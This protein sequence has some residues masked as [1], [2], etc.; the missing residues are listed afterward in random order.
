MNIKQL[1]LKVNFKVDNT[2]DKCLVNSLM[3]SELKIHSVWTDI[4]HNWGIYIDWKNKTIGI[5]H[6][7][8]LNF[9]GHVSFLWDHWY[10][11]FGLLVTFP[12]GS[13]L[14][15]LSRGIHVTLHIPWDSP[16]VQ[17][18]LT[19]WWPSLPHTCKALVGLETRSYHA[20]GHSVRSGRPDFI[21]WGP[22][23]YRKKKRRFSD[24][25]THI[26]L[27]NFFKT[28]IVVKYNFIFLKYIVVNC[29]FQQ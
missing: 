27:N 16:L 29:N 3:L 11:Y 24:V 25:P 19:S 8:F 21:V 22:T 5:L 23:T 12:L 26:E 15:E 14:F 1:L 4:M 7:F 20:A 13:A 2:W 18:L 10:P 6:V 28:Y 17:H 9:G